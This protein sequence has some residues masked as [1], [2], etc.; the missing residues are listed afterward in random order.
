MAKKENSKSKLRNRNFLVD[1]QE[2]VIAGLTSVLRPVKPLKVV[3]SNTAITQDLPDLIE[4]ARADVV[5]VDVVIGQ[6]M[7]PK[8]EAFGI[9]GIRRIRRK[10]GPEMG[11]IAYSGYP[12]DDFKELCL[13]AGA[14]QYI[15]KNR[16]LRP[17]VDSLRKQQY[18]QHSYIKSLKLECANT[19]SAT[20][21][22]CNENGELSST[23]IGLTANEFA[24]LY[25]LA[26]E[27]SR[28]ESDWLAR[29]HSSQKTPPYR[30]K[31]AALWKQICSTLEARFAEKWE[32]DNISHCVH[33]IKSR[34]QGWGSSSYMELIIVPGGGR[35]PHLQSILPS[36]YCL[37]EFIEPSSIT[38]TGRKIPEAV[39]AA[40]AAESLPESSPA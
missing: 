24:L 17:L 16:E 7:K 9:V 21:E 20:V 23:I 6:G 35:H 2:I 3:G 34:I 1:D 27:R 37:N 8:S 4:K 10:F 14:D 32:N 22:I 30:F 15:I 13:Q 12:E 18:K 39:R 40:S 11:I 31:N 33:D 28:G 26:Q 5:V 38:F 29:E 25:Y 36:M 19:L